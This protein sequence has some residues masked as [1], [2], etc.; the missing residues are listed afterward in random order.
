[1]LLILLGIVSQVRH[2]DLL[3][4]CD[5]VVRCFCSRG[6]ARRV[7]DVGRPELRFSSDR[8]VLEEQGCGCGVFGRCKSIRKLRGGEVSDAKVKNWKRV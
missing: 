5:E 7:V 3:T 2:F 8:E 6:S 4:V 1:M